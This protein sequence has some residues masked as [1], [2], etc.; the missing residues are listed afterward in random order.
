MVVPDLEFMVQQMIMMGNLNL[1]FK[2][3]QWSWPFSETLLSLKGLQ[4][5]L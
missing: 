4:Q 2:R 3:A 5:P 1:A